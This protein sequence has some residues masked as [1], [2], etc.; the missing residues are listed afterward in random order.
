MTCLVQLL[1]ADLLSYSF[2]ASRISVWPGPPPCIGEEMPWEASS[3]SGTSSAAQS[4]GP[5]GDSETPHRRRRS[6]HLWHGRRHVAPTSSISGTGTTRSLNSIQDAAPSNSTTA[7]V[8]IN[9]SP[10]RVDDSDGFASSLDSLQTTPSSG[11]NRADSAI[12]AR[13]PRLA[14][15]PITVTEPP[16]APYI[17]TRPPPKPGPIFMS[18]EGQELRDYAASKLNNY[19]QL[20]AWA[21]D[22]NRVRYLQFG[23]LPCPHCSP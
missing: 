17:Y 10:P 13:H 21:R 16:V 18:L 1:S 4:P 11:H 23:R 5:V 3:G 9:S 20:A 8:S 12:A 19:D 2:Q 14:V 7:P 6:Q 22:A 15:G